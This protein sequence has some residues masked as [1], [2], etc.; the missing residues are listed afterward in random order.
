[1]N[2]TLKLS[3]LVAEGGHVGLP[4][5]VLSLLTWVSAKHDARPKP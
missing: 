1:M 5:D 2:P 4:S 3:F